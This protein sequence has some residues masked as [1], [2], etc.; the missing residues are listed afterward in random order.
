M[1]EFLQIL[2]LLILV[3]VFVWPKL[4]TFLIWLIL[5]TYPHGWWAYNSILPLNIGYDDLFCISLFLI[6]FLRRNI[7]GGMPIRFGYAFWVITA[8]SIIGVIANVSGM[9]SSV[10][11]TH[12][13]YIKDIL[14]MGVYWCLFYSILHCIDNERD[15]KFQYTMFSIA[16]VIGAVLVI[17]QYYFPYRL[18]I[19][20]LPTALAEG[21]F[22]YGDRGSGAFT[23]PNAAAC[24]LVCSLVMVVVALRLQKKF[25]SKAVIYSFIFVLLSGILF[26]RSRAGLLALVGVILPMALVGRSKKIAG[27][28]FLATIIVSIYF[29]GIRELYQERVSEVYDPSSGAWGQ[30]VVGRVDMW[31]RYFATASLK[32]YVLGQGP[33]QGILKNEMESHSAYVSLI[34]VYG[35]AA[36]IWAIFSLIF[37]LKKVL[38]LRHLQDPLI[39]AVSRGCFWALVAWGIYATSSD[40]ITSQYPRYLLFYFVVLL[41]RVSFFARQQQAEWFYGQET[42]IRQLPLEPELVY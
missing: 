5:F 33:R 7:L 13:A 17:L 27:M 16:A 41:D 31:K 12:T 34:T 38:G 9:I 36:V 14:K 37:F 2:A 15:L 1:A 20:A 26:T 21:G 10:E 6:V 23:N 42:D 30:N 19:F 29:A 39:T 4:G 24:V 8:F 28:V 18:E 3:V 32:D 22:R 11:F 25:I 35:V 40:A